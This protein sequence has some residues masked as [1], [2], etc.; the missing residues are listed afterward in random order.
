MGKMKIEVTVR[1]TLE[2][3]LDAYPKDKVIHVQC[4]WPCDGK[5][6]EYAMVTVEG[7]PE[8][9]KKAIKEECLKF[10]IE[11]VFRTDGIFEVWAK[12]CETVEWRFLMEKEDAE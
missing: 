8:F 12:E 5:G 10:G 9:V 11:G 2:Q 7:L 1:P 6:G 3:I 4:S